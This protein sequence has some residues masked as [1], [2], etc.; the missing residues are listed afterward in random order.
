M[1]P[2]RWIE[3]D[4]AIESLVSGKAPGPDGMPASL[5]GRLPVLREVLVSSFNAVLLTGR[6]PI[7]LTRVG[8]DPAKSSI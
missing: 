5:Y 8:E 6:L 2:V 1:A 4:M 3:V 7:S